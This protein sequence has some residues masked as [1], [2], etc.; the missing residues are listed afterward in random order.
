[1]TQ[2]DLINAP[3]HYIG[4]NG[5]QG[6]DVINALGW[7]FPF[8]LGNAVK[9]LLRAGRKSSDAVTDLRKCKRNLEMALE[10][11]PPRPDDDSFGRR[12]VVRQA[13]T[14]FGLNEGRAEILRELSALSS[15][16]GATALRFLAQT[17]VLVD[18]EIAMAQATACVVAHHGQDA[19]VTS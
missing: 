12:I 1:M 13:V 8:C 7:G 2:P 11:V 6:I 10:L 16:S 18:R 5:L 3:P 9:Y 14:G 19:Q 17:L 15:M 4:S